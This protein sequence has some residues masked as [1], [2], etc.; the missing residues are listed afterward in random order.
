MRTLGVQMMAVREDFGD[1]GD[2]A[3]QTPVTLD[4]SSSAVDLWGRSRR[5]DRTPGPIRV[6]ASISNRAAHARIVVESLGS[7]VFV[8]PGR[9]YRTASAMSVTC[10]AEVSTTM[11]A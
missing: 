6:S 7:P 9:R 11:R 4:A 2:G 1:Q 10:G 3:A 5:R 8:E